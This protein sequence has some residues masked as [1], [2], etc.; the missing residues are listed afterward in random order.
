MQDST[1]KI[2]FNILLM[3]SKMKINFDEQINRIG[4]N[5]GKFDEIQ[6]IYGI[7]PETGL[8]MWTADMDFRPPKCVIDCLKKQIDHGILQAHDLP[9][10]RRQ[11]ILIFSHQL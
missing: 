11:T 8:A 4:T 3:D 1:I 5:S 7:A 9:N 10:R 2:I 6:S